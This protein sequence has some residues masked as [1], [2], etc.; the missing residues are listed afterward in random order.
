MPKRTLEKRDIT[1]SLLAGARWLMNPVSEG[2]A[3]Q[4]PRIKMLAG[5]PEILADVERMRVHPTGGRL[6]AERPDLGVSLSDTAALKAMPARSLGRAFFD[7]MDNPYGVPGYLLA[8]LIYR[9]GFFDSFEISDDARYYLERARWMHDLFNVVTGY[10]PNLSGEGL[11]IYFQHAYLYGVSYSKLAWSSFGIGPRFFIQPSIGTKRWRALLMEAHRNGLAAHA[12]CPA[13]FVAWEERGC[14]DDNFKFS[15]VFFMTFIAWLIYIPLQILWMPLSILGA[16]WV[17]YKQIVRS[18]ALG[19]SQTAVEIVNGRWTGDVFGLREDVASRKLAGTLTNNSVLGLRITLF[20]LLV[21]RMIA[22]RPILY[23]QLPEDDKSG[24]ANMVFSRSRRF[25][26]L[27][28]RYADHAEQLVVLGAGLDT[29]AY[30]P[31]AEQSLAMFEL[32]MA[33]TQKA[34]RQ[35]VK[36]ANLN[37]NHVHYV[38]VDFADP[39]W[40]NALVASPYDPAKKTIFLWEGVTLY[41][42][43][44]NVRAT[45][46]AIKAHAAQGSVVVLDFYGERMLKMARKGAM[47]KSLEATGETMDFGF[48]FA[49]DAEAVLSAFVTSVGYQLG[50]HYF[51]GSSHKAGA[52]MVIAALEI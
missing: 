38:E 43:E 13:I 42:S 22:G 8:G 30:G 18:K 25:D 3:K 36:R 31:L 14:L 1:S 41:L 49:R 37:F 6:L 20:P 46:A 17:A 39:N 40:I 4:V 34:K 10:A 50:P 47:A 33:A 29:R 19:L 35:A 28:E 27:I 48:D 5:G 26:S 51:L 9:D 7:S 12:V 24:I 16:L 45:L 2:G 11:L 52:Y 32:D 15:I 23:P 44:T 21:A